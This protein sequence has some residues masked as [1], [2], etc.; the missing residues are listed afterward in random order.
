[1]AEPMNARDFTGSHPICGEFVEQL[2]VWRFTERGDDHVHTVPPR[3]PGP[4]WRW[5][6]GGD[7]VAVAVAT[8]TAT[9]G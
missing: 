2:A 1:M 6:C 8:A 7:D 9:I 5:R 3:L 4:S